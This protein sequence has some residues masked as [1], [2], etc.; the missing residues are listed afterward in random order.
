MLVPE[1]CEYVHDL[2]WQKDLA[3][4]IQLRTLDHPSDL[5]LNPDGT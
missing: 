2:T 4:V 3:H 1:A 5:D